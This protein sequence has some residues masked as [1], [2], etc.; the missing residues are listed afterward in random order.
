M[1]GGLLLQT[2]RNFHVLNLPSSS[3]TKGH[4]ERSSVP[5]DSLKMTC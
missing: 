2:A 1:L 4:A 3:C 5:D